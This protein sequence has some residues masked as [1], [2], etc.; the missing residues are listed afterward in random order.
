LTR[1]ERPTASYRSGRLS[2]LRPAQ[3]SR[4]LRDAE[5]GEIADFVD[6]ADRMVQ[7]DGHIRANYITRLAAVGAA[8]SEWI[9]GRTGDPERD[10]YAEA[11]ARFCADRAAE[12][13]GDDRLVMEMLDAVGIGIS[14]HEKD[15]AWRD[16]G[17]WTIDRFR[18]V[19]QRR[20][21]FDEEWAPRIVDLG[22]GRRVP[23]GVRLSRWSRKF[24]VHQSRE[25]A[26]DPSCTGV[27]RSVAWLY[28]FKRWAM[29]FWVQGAERF[30]WPM[31]VATVKRGAGEESRRNL[32]RILEDFT[33]EHRAVLDEGDTVQML[34]SQLKDAGTWKELTAT[35]N[36]EIGKALLGS[37]DQTEP[38][39]IGAWK[40]VESRKAT[41]VDSRQ[42]LDERQLAATYRRDVCEPLLAYNTHLW[43]GVMPPVPTRRW[44]IAETRKSIPREALEASAV[45]VDELRAS[46]GLDPWGPE[47]GGDARATLG[48]AP[49]G[50][51]DVSA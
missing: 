46:L 12:Y 45:T 42:A 37:V 30:A 26:T 44:V 17:Y 11:A 24:V 48:D 7:L 2:S 18:F 8:R 14:V 20:L 47:M 6:L 13:E 40:A 33:T 32:L 1:A 43:G 35:L 36:A 29:Q 41:T 49:E 31:V 9:P 15:Y 23:G 51:G 16:E 22:G 27:L 28:L 50:A 25:H 19:H 10:Q 21:K 5:R 4:I 39:E 38:S 3:V 34:E